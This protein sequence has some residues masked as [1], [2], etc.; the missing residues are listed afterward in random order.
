MIIRP[1][2]KDAIVEE[3]THLDHMT[4]RNQ[5]GTDKEALVKLASFHTS[6]AI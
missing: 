3:I 6:M 4:W 1:L 5:V 2:Y